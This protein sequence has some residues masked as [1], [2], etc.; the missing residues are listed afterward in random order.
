VLSGSWARYAPLSGLVF[1]ALLVATLIIGGEG[2]ETDDSTLKVVRFWTEND[3][4]QITAAILGAL[5]GVPLLWFL[6]S[7]RSTLRA[8]EGGTGRLSALAFAGG[9]VLV[10]GATVDSS[11]QFVV[12]DS[13]GD[14]PPTV[15]QALSVLYSDFF[16]VFPVGISVWLLASALVVLRFGALP[17]W[18]GWA[19]L[20][21]GI[22]ALTPAGFFSFVGVFA[23]VAVV[24]IVLFRQSAPTA[25]AAPVAATTG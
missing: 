11:L 15:T 24:S 18:L 12:A 3:S 4:E 16:F 19:A 7:L 6:G 13:A 21:L 25:P 23:W 9:I 8:A 20:V 17:A 5:A 2:P 14:V 22:V 1:V 10:A